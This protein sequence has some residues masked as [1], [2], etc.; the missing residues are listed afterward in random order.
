MI[1]EIVMFKDVV[2]DKYTLLCKDCLAKALD[3]F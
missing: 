3:L 1:Q 2:A